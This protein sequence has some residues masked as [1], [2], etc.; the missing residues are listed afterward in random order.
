MRLKKLMS[1][2]LACAM[3]L[4]LVTVASA[5]DTRIYFIEDFSSFETSADFISARAYNTDSVSNPAVTIPEGKIPFGW[6]T[7][8]SGPSGG[9]HDFETNSFGSK[10][11]RQYTDLAMEK[12]PNYVTISTSYKLS[13]HM[14][15]P[16]DF[17]E[18]QDETIVIT[19]EYMADQ[20]PGMS[21][22]TAYAG[23]MHAWFTDSSNSTGKSF[24]MLRER[25]G[26]GKAASGTE[27][28]D[29]YV[30]ATRPDYTV[31]D[32]PDGQG[33]ASK[34]GDAQTIANETAVRTAVGF[35]YNTATNPYRYYAIDGKLL[36]TGTVDRGTFSSATKLYA[37][38]KSMFGSMGE[39]MA[40]IRV[41]S[42][43]TNDFKV[44]AET[45]ANVPV[46][47]KT[48]RI[49]FSNLVAPATYTAATTDAIAV[50]ADGVAME[51]DA[52][53]VGAL[54]NVI[55]KAGGEI[56]SY[57]DITFDALEE[58]T[59]YTV[60]F[61]AT[62]AN[63]I[64]TTLAGKNVA[65]FTTKYPDVKVN[66]L[67]IVGAESLIADGSLQATKLELANTTTTSKSVAVIYAVYSSNGQLADV[68]YV[69]DTIA[70]EK[71]AEIET[72]MKL[73]T[74]GTLKTFVW[75]TMEAL[76]PYTGSNTLTIAAPAAAE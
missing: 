23:T 37:F 34:I 67:T 17:V 43:K 56:Y 9:Y 55:G 46:T 70:A 3:A 20:F 15:T 50:K 48:M 24:S 73:S 27:G 53:S 10:A 22:L 68:A 11:F 47:T 35:S 64:G 1:L 13:F 51:E 21:A 31:I 75:N 4:S 8:N 19:Y 69:N 74:V 52:Y 72:G 6:Y 18:K 41:Y 61:P 25:A 54:K 26:A 76:K 45:A 71:T 49:Y 65:T 28:E 16:W 2:V 63:E 62:I 29:D 5:A 59:T 40:N 32:F 14:D 39:S 58:G 36:A 60:E 44:T 38:D 7:S 42:I 30:A 33:G 12:Q 57:V 66:S